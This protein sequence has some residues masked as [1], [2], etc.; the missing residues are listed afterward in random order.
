M[1]IV[2]IADLSVLHEHAMADVSS[3]GGSKWRWLLKTPATLP[4]PITR[5]CLVS[6]V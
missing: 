3:S 2:G 5:V 4:K 1:A 6:A